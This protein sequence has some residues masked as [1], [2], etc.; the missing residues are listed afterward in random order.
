MSHCDSL[1]C[2]GT[3]C[4]CAGLL[5]WMQGSRG[6][7]APAALQSPKT[8]TLLV[9]IA[10]ALPLDVDP[11]CHSVIVRCA[12]ACRAFVPDFKDGYPS[13]FPLSPTPPRLL[14]LSSL[15]SHQGSRRPWGRLVLMYLWPPPCPFNV[16]PECRSVI[17][18]C[19]LARRAFVPDFKDGSWQMTHLQ[20]FHN[21]FKLFLGCHFYFH[22]KGETL[23]LFWTHCGLFIASVQCSVTN[24]IC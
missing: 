15:P 13:H 6:C 10:P 8:L 5:R 4:I 22:Y 11:K 2:F 24:K 17:V 16:G 3:S 21:G 7:Q 14:R 19:A 23:E 1:M 12:L 18:R 20:L 9:L